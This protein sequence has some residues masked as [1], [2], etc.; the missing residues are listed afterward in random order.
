M[1]LTLN[2]LNKYLHAYSCRRKPKENRKLSVN[3]TRKCII[4]IFDKSPALH[5]FKSPVLTAVLR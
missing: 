5:L 2:L 3:P 4:P 1:H